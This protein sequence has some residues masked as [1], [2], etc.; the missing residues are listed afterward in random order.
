MTVTER[1]KVTEEWVKAVKKTDQ[2]LMVQIGGAPLPDVLE[3][4]LNQIILLCSDV[5]DVLFRQSMLIQLVRT[6]F[7]VY[8]I[9]I[10]SL[11][12]LQILLD[13]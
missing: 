6:L 13:T 3:L 1:K 4:V 11:Q 2:H 5:F 10:T 8:L 9:S 12:L 7:S